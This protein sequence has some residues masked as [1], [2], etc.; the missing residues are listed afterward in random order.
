MMKKALMITLYLLIGFQAKALFGGPDLSTRMPASDRFVS[1]KTK[2][3]NGPS[4]DLKKMKNI[5]MIHA[6]DVGKLKY[7]GTTYEQAFSRVTDECF[8]KRTQIFV[9]NRKVHPDQDRQIQFAES[10]VN[11]VKCI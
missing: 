3:E 5:C 10:C 9:Q 1:S 11:A 6:G 4:V 8:Q 2:T 7:K